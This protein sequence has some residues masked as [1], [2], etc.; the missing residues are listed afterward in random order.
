MKNLTQDSL[1]NITSGLEYI[2][3]IIIRLLNLDLQTK[4]TK[5]Y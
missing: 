4:V 2:Q 3:R 5:F 1:D